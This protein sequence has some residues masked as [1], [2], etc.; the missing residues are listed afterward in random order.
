MV[1][2]EECVKGV[3]EL[4]VCIWGRGE[5]VLRAVECGTGGKEVCAQGVWGEERGI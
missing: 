5:A 3:S 1:C 4:V 2:A